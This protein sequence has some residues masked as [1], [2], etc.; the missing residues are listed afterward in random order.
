[1]YVQHDSKVKTSSPLQSCS[2]RGGNTTP[3]HYSYH[4][5]RNLYKII[6]SCHSSG[7]C[8]TISKAAGAGTA[9]VYRGATVREGMPLSTWPLPDICDDT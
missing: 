9:N 2:C 3:Q 6:V 8:K 1:M 7:V 5:S 4:Y